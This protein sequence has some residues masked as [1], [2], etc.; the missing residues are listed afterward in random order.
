MTGRPL[1]RC[2]ALLLAAVTLAGCGSDADPSQQEEVELGGQTTEPS[3]V[4]TETEEA[5]PGETAQSPNRGVRAGLLDERDAESFDT[6]ARRLG[7]EVGL[8]VG[9][10]GAADAEQLGTLS[11]GAAWST[12]KVPIAAKVLEQAGGP[13]GL[14]S[15]QER[16]I[17]AALTAS[18]NAAADELFA[19]LGSDEQAAAA[20]GEVLS[21]AGDTTTAVSARGRDGFSPYGQTEWSLSEQ[22]RFMARLAGGCV[23]GGATSE[24]LLSLM[25]EVVPD[26]RWGAGSAGAGSARF[27]GGW[28]PGTD[29]RYL[30]RQMGVLEVDGGEVVVTLAA[31][32]PDGGFAS[33]TQTLTELATWVTENVNADNANPGEC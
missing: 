10:P 14:S 4:G 24:Y 1:A 12:I 17:A 30:V 26:Q 5:E 22:H 8:T 15:G 28:G 32:A 11:S 3:P 6:L 9:V 7:G 13:D 33:G 16:S 21:E 31:I 27:K 18:D 19:S 2:L 25:G 23:A 20:T 29:G